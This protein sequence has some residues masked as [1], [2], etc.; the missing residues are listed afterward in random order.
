MT[1]KTNALPFGLAVFSFVKEKLPREGHYGPE[2]YTP[3]P[4]SHLPKAGTA[5]GVAGVHRRR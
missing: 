1:A 2:A 4:P 3:T 5:S